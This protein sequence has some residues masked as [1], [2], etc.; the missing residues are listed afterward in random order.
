MNIKLSENEIQVVITALRDW[1]DDRDSNQRLDDRTWLHR[2]DAAADL[3][4][5]L[6]SERDRPEEPKRKCPA[7]RGEAMCGNDPVEW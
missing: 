1:M 7:P 4:H 5:R 3:V 2:Q 6:E